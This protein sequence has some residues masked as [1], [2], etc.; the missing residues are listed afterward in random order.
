VRPRRIVILGAGPS[1]LAAALALSRD[2]HATTLIER[3]PIAPCPSRDAPAW[4]RNGI[5]HFLSPHAFIPRGRME[6]KSHFGDV[7]ESMIREGA[8]VVD[9]RRKLPGALV[10]EDEELQYI[11]VRRPLIEWALRNAVAQDPGITVRDGVRVTGLRVERGRVAGID[12]EGGSIDA[13]VVV[14]AMGR[15]SPMRGW[16]AAL[17]IDAFTRERS[18]CGVIY[19]SRYYRLRPGRAFPDGPWLISPRGDLGYMGFM[20]FPGDNGTFAG[21]LA[22]PTGVPEMKVFR[23]EAAFEAAVARIPL[24]RMWNDPELV[25]PITPV[26]PMGGLQNA[27]QAP[28]GSAPAGLFWMGDA[29]CHTDPVLAHGLSFALIHAVEIARALRER[30]SLNDAAGAYFEAALPWLRERYDF[31]TALD[32]QRL[33]A[34]RGEPVDFTRRTGDYALFSFNAA[35]AVAMEDPDVFRA[36]VR[37]IGLL[38]STRALDENVALQE[39]IEERF[40][41]IRARPRPAPGPPRDEMLEIAEAAAAGTPSR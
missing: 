6:M 33:R 25:E 14:D 24:L 36:F 4:E 11:S 8:D 41:A 21:G 13:E 32:A 34:W 29:L 19:Y 1:G 9:V 7:Y 31:V 17:G 38:D 23:H 5:P 35:G 12:A 2:G 15:G 18:D 30:D 22:V 27:I 39:R 10:P 16:L 40:G 20:S 3:D 28:N 26:Q 37:R